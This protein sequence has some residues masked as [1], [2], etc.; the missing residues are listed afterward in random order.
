MWRTRYNLPSS[1]LR[2]G[3]KLKQKAIA[4]P[5][6]QIQEATLS[7]APMLG[8]RKAIS[9]HK[10][11]LCLKLHLQTC[12]G[13]GALHALKLDPASS[14]LV[15]RQTQAIFNDKQ[16]LMNFKACLVLAFID[17]KIIW[18]LPA[19]ADGPVRQPQECTGSRHCQDPVQ[20]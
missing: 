4:C 5:M 19:H 14:C 11:K 3:E 8:S 6:S 15:R 1:V 18:L 7:T 20:K 17:H 16:T 12:Q 9:S 2:R 10:L 13:F